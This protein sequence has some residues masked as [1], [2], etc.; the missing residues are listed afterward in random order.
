MPDDTDNLRR[1]LYNGTCH[2][3]QT[4]TLG[5]E[6]S[7]HLARVLRTRVGQSVLVFTGRGCEYLG[8]VERAHQ[9]AARVRIERQLSAQSVLEPDLLVA[10]GPPPGQRTDVLI[11]K[12][13]EAGAT[14]LQPLVTKRLQA[15]QARAA[16][17]RTERWERKAR[18]AAR[19]AGRLVVPEVREPVD[20]GEFAAEAGPGVRLVGAHVRAR[21]FWSVLAGWTEPPAAVTVAVGPAGGFTDAELADAERAGFQPVA[22]G[23]H[24]LRVETAA[25]CMLGAV[26][27][28]LHALQEDKHPSE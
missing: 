14:A 19:Q 20:W 7:R 3:G 27:L 1:F 28:R 25:I 6:Q 2:P 16:R 17:R 24:T 5:P 15:G 26:V 9:R 12:T 21:P 18:D 13:T 10:F 23:P 11:E 8:T 4:V 22:L